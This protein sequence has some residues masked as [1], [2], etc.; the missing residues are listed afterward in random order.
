MN[1]KKGISASPGVA[2]GPAFVLDTERYRIK[3]RKVYAS[4]IP[5]ELRQLEAALEAARQEVADIRL[6]TAR[7]HGQKMA[8]IFA[9]H[10]G[11]IGDPSVRKA[12][13]ALIEGSR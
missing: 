1:A 13:A 11:F 2:I 6:A 9:F 8:E 12:V 5:P 7:K 3:Q 10:E 4:G